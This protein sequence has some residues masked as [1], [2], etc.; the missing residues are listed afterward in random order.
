MSTVNDIEVTIANG[1]ITIKNTNN[2][3]ASIEK[4][5][6]LNVTSVNEYYQDY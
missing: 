2:P 1:F 3:N 5:N 6:L 4:Y